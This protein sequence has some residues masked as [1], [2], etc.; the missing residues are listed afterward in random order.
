MEEEIVCTVL[1]CIQL[2][3][4]EI[5]MCCVLQDEESYTLP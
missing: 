5:K 4:N 1:P 3:L 2:D